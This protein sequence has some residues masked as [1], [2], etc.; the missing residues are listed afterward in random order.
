MNRQLAAASTIALLI[1]LVSACSA[2]VARHDSTVRAQVTEQPDDAHFLF[3]LESTLLENGFTIHERALD[4]AGYRYIVTWTI[5]SASQQFWQ[6]QYKMRFN[7][8]VVASRATDSWLVEGRF[9]TFDDQHTASIT[10]DFQT[11][12]VDKVSAQLMENR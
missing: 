12:V 1:I 2:P 6:R 7:G 11:Y 3:L 4:T 8:E 10:Q 9:G 5:P